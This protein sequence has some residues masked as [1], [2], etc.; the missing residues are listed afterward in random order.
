MSNTKKMKKLRKR[1]IGGVKNFTRKTPAVK[2]KSFGREG[3]IT[4]ATASRSAL[5]SKPN[6]HVELPKT[7][8]TGMLSALSQY[9]HKKYMGMHIASFMGPTETALKDELLV[10]AS[11]FP[12]NAHEKVVITDD[13]NVVIAGITE[14]DM[15][16]FVSG[17][18]RRRF[19]TE[20]KV[21][22]KFENCKFVFTFSGVPSDDNVNF[23]TLENLLESFTTLP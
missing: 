23:K 17:E 19:S 6:L 9:P 5:M 15:G 1:T 13:N 12:N 20:F 8:R 22:V 21:T 3:F 16:K 18:L 4:F 2:G 11:N 7:S 14:E 10:F